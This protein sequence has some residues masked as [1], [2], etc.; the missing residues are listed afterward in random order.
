LKIRYVRQNPENLYRQ[1][2]E[3]FETLLMKGDTD[4]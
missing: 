4:A 1:I 2:A 3:P